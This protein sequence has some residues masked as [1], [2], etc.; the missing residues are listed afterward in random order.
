MNLDDKTLSEIMSLTANLKEEK[1]VVAERVV[2]LPK[3][4]EVLKEKFRK[5]NVRYMNAE[6]WLE[7][8]KNHLEMAIGR[9]K[10]L[11]ELIEELEAEISARRK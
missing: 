10:Q 11:D 7:Q 9:D 8:A 3:E 1:V 4:I 5:A 6:G 2:E